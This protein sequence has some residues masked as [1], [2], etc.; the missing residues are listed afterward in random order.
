MLTHIR[1]TYLEYLTS[2]QPS[3]FGREKNQVNL[4]KTDVFYG[5]LEKNYSK[6]VI[7]AQYD[8]A[9]IFCVLFS[10]LAVNHRFL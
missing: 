4:L 7:T 1:N 3:G 5:S 9:N 6:K 2:F 8:D 10:F